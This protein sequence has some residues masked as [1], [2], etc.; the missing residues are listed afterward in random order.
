MFATYTDVSVADVPIASLNIKFKA[1]TTPYT[2]SMFMNELKVAT[3]GLT[4]VIYN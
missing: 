1:D 4:F 3:G 2:I